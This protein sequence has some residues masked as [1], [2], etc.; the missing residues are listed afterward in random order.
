MMGVDK[1]ALLAWLGRK[2]VTENA[3]IGAV[4]DGLI[5]RI[6]RGEFDEEEVER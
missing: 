5:S 4:Y 6:K 3:L 1:A 2:A